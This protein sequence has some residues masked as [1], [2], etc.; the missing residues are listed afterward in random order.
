MEKI[1]NNN[2]YWTLLRQ[3][4]WN[5]YMA[6]TSKGLCYI[7][8]QNKSFEEMALWVHTRFPGGVLV[9]DDLE[10]K[11]YKEE[12]VEYLQGVRTVFTVPFDFRGTQFQLAV[13][14]ALCEI[15]YGRTWSYSDIAAY[16]GRPGSVRAVGT[17]IGA[18]PVL[19]TVP[20][21][22]VIGK[23][24]ALTGYRGGLEMKTQ[25]LQL[26]QVSSLVNANT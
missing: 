14:H 11:P 1:T 22:R 23:N 2:I 10:I 24:G 9:Q 6:A 13:W 4:H 17:A 21:H 26:E 5:I 12:L 20:C 19:I 16:I 8:S 18:N 7:G 3:D 25:L 15:P